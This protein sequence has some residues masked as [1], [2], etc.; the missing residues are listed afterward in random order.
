MTALLETVFGRTSR[1]I[2]HMETDGAAL[3]ISGLSEERAAFAR[4]LSPS[5][6]QKLWF[7]LTRCLFPEKSELIIALVSTA[8]LPTRTSVMLTTH[9]QIAVLNDGALEVVGLNE[10]HRWQ[11]CL[12]AR[13]AHALWKLLDILLY[14]TGWGGRAPALR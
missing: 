10:H 1:L 5:A 6:A 7:H 11:M 13:D 9:V 12:S 2:L 14:P 8:P 4:L 3:R